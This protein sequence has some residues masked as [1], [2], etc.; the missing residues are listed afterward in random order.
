MWRRQGLG[1]VKPQIEIDVLR[2]VV[3]IFRHQLVHLGY[4]AKDVYGIAG[5]EEFLTAYYN[6]MRRIVG[7]WP[8]AVHRANGFASPKDP[9]QARAL[10]SIEQKLQNG[11]S[12][13]PYLSRKIRDLRYNDLLFNDWGI[14][15]F[16]L[17]TTVEEH[18]FVNRTGPLLYVVLGDTIDFHS[19]GNTDAHLITIMGHDDFATQVLVEIIYDNWPELLSQFSFRGVSGDRLSDSDIRRLRQMHTNYCL[20]LRDGTSCFSPGGGITSAGTSAIDTY[21]ALH[22]VW[23]AEKQQEVVLGHMPSV[24]ERE[25]TS[26]QRRFQKVIDLRLRMSN[27]ATGSWIL[28][29][30]NSGYLHPLLHI[31]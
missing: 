7:P 5:D 24:I 20:R 10:S 1:G 16:H 31:G 29:D 15:H 17:G 8:R 4:S 13:I 22:R 3:E 6:A 30:E 11:E 26:G 9:D 2:D 25:M 12:V 28:V 23:W 19:T 21:R 14:H 27:E 18:G